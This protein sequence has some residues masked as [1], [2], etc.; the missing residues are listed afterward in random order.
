MTWCCAASTLAASRG[1]DY[2]YPIH[3]RYRDDPIR[4]VAL[5]VVLALDTSLQHTSLTRLRRHALRSLWP[6]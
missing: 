2:A 1:A 5:V 6:S 3:N 4:C